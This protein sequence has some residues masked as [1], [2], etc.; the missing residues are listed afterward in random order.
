MVSSVNL[1]GLYSRWTDTG[2]A[3]SAG[4]ISD[5]KSLS[6]L[7][8][9]RGGRA[10]GQKSCELSESPGRGIYQHWHNGCCHEVGGSHCWDEGQVGL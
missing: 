2:P 7:I 3:L 4:R 10:T 6:N 1:L 9:M 8:A 5:G